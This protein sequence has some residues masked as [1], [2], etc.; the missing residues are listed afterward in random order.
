MIQDRKLF[1]VGNRAFNLRHLL[2]IGILAASFSISAMVR[3]Q[4]AD[5]GFQLNE[6][7]P[8]FNFRATEYL[9]NHGVDAYVHWHDTLSW[10]PEGRDVFTNAQ[11]PLH[12]TD[13]I[14]Y[15]IFGGGMSLYDFTII[16]PVVFGSLTT[17]IV[18]ALVRVI[19]GTTSG[20]FASLFFAISPPI[21]V[22][23][24]IGWFKSEP[25][26]LFYGLLGVYLFLSGIRTQNRKIAIAKLFG[27]AGFLSI[28][29]ASW[30]GVEFFLIPLGIFV[31]ALPFVR[32]DHNFLLWA[33]PFFVA[34]TMAVSGGVFAR[35]GPTFVFGERG[36]VLIG[37]TIL[38]V[39]IIFVQKFSKDQVKLRNSLLVLAACI[40]IGGAIF[41]SGALHSASFRYLNAVDPFLTSEDPLVDSVAEHATPT[42]AQN[43]TYFSILMLFAGFGIWL[44][45]RKKSEGSNSLPFNIKNEMIIFA[46]ILG[47]VGAYAGSTFSRLELLTASSVIV[48]ASVGLAAM[49]SEI[50]KKENKPAVT[51]SK[52]SKKKVLTKKS[53]IYM[54]PIPKIAFVVVVVALLLVP[55]MFPVDANWI[56]M[57]KA[58]PTILN[59]GSN[60]AIATTDWPDALNWLK[61]NTPPN[62]VIASWW[63]YGYWIQTLGHRTTFVDNATVDTN[64][65]AGIAKMFLASPDDAWKMLRDMHAD[66]V[67]VYV[68]GQKFV[69]N[70]QELYVLG[71]GGDESKKQW[72]I[73]I[74]G[75]D[76]T[77]F[78]QS[79]EFTPT[80]YF[81]QNTLLGHMFPFTTVTY[82][83]PTTHSE[84]QTYQSGFTAIYAK[85]IKYPENG[86]GPLKLVYQSSSLNRT[87]SGVF[88]GVLIYQVNADYSQAAYQQQQANSTQ[89]QANNTLAQVPPVPKV[90]T[91]NS[92]S[93]TTGDTAVI[94]T[95]YGDITLR[96]FNNVAPKTVANFEKLA[97]SGFYD[98]TVFH[99]IVPGFVIQGGDH[100]SIN[101]SRDTWGMGDA[102]YTIPPEFSD[103]N[104]TTYTVGM[105][106][107]QD[108]N[109]G[110][111]QFFIT[112]GDAS[113]LNG[114]YTLFGQVI[115]GQDVV[116]KIAALPTDSNS[117]PVNADDARVTT[118]KILTNSTG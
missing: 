21:I 24:T 45:F 69:S 70:G 1:T 96:L 8:Y 51:E 43:F 55:T 29:F 37:S 117:Q 74:A 87:D 95:K 7:D 50:L 59:G 83:D 38:M 36:F 27:G 89:S 42:L 26:G 77:Q 73:K 76:E 111:S 88:S 47:I 91:T 94:T 103:L 35:P 79:D 54:G 44:T 48:L 40:V 63:D 82:Y 71:G 104:F 39:V 56:S 65:I 57:V 22:R 64:K 13:A 10:Y 62:S 23:G 98:Q 30:G 18:F 60:F 3:S 115:S 113:F 2:V 11:V 84:S 105:A 72:F 109:S 66:Y 14:L 19:G 75:E 53:L 41:A 99:R 9:L 5:Y 58:P 20:L 16:F 108:V 68:V 31:I 118:I 92:S 97:K 12:F 28:G 107:G 52:D 46:L 102:G 80:D 32:K 6:F 4:A 86:N 78:L 114:K 33:I 81:W 112:V 100:N 116:D 49:T 61:T 85:N 15:K 101:G 90:T 34:I 25:L 110:S 106:R 67:V 93:T 17:V